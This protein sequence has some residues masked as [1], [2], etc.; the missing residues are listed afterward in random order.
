MTTQKK[1]NTKLTNELIDSRLLNEKRPIVRVSNVVNSST[2]LTWKCTDCDHAWNA[3]PN[4][5][6]NLKSGCPRCSGKLKLTNADIDRAL[7]TRHIVRVGDYV[8]YDTPIQWKCIACS[9]EWMSSPNNILHGTGCPV[10]SDTIKG[11][12]KSLSQ[13]D[14]VH[15]I[16]AYKQ[17]TLITPYTRIIDKHTIK[18]QTCSYVWDIRLNDVVNNHHGCPSCAG[19]VKLTNDKIDKR[20]LES[21][22]SLIRIGDVVNATTKIEWKCQHNHIWKAT[23][24]SVLNLMSGCPVCGRVGF[25]SK[26]YFERNPHKRN[27]PGLVY[28]IEG[29]YNDTRFIKIG[30]TEKTVTRRFSGD[31][32]KYQIREIARKETTLWDA[33]T[34]EQAILQQYIGDLHQPSDEFDEKTEC[35]RYD[36][37]IIEDILD[38]YFTDAL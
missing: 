27:M 38:T 8:N 20:L 19:L 37:K 11:K 18:C 31:I 23:P 29:T 9:N 30:I 21:N 4:S 5:V 35:L 13:Y 32:K 15:E 36:P 6:L 12:A 16:L 14:R 34:I 26:R 17:L 10:C 25:A 33:Y 28:L 1:T 2:K 24:D 22:R 7:G 3:T